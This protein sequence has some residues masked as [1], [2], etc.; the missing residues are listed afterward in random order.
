M[1]ASDIMTAEVKTIDHDATI[2]EAIALL[3]S[4]HV[5]GLPVAD[6]DGRLVG[7]VSEGDFLHR[8]ELGTVKRKPRWIEFLLGPGEIAQSYVLSHGRKVHEVMTRDVVTI[9]PTASLT[10]VVEI[11][12]K[13]SVKRLPVVSADRLV[14]IITR[15]DLLRAL[16]DVVAAKSQAGPGDLSDS[17]I[18]DRLLAELQEQGIASPRTLDVQVEEGVVT[19]TGEIFDERQ[20]PAIKVAA[21][22]IPGVV[23]VIDKLVWIEPYSGIALG[24]SDAI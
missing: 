14:G 12:E 13:Q 17:E 5:S 8:P 1:K 3:L 11:M 7:V 24:K 22:N 9:H 15:S 21:E 6:R 23:K 19:L 20:R 10:E 18:R 2:D 16:S 4:A